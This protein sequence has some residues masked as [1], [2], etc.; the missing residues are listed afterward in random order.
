MPKTKSVQPTTT[1]QELDFSD[2]EEEIDPELCTKAYFDGNG[3]WLFNV[4]PSDLPAVN[5]IVCE[6]FVRSINTAIRLYKC[7]DCDRVERT[8]NWVRLHQHAQTEHQTSIFKHKVFSEA[9]DSKSQAKRAMT[10]RHRRRKKL[11][12]GLQA[13]L[14]QRRNASSTSAVTG[15]QTDIQMQCVPPPMAVKSPKLLAPW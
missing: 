2:A 10:D 15:I 6:P 9:Q 14:D 4:V 8:E 5:D 13:Q 3:Q 1:Q 12:K 11:L 7:P